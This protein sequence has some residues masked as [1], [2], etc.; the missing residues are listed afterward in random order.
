MSNYS[1]YSTF[2]DQDIVRGVCWSLAIISMPCNLIVI[3]RLLY[4]NYRYSKTT[5]KKSAFSL[6]HHR[7]AISR[8]PSIFLLFNLTLS[9]LVSSLYLLILAFSDV[10]YTDYY[11]NKYGLYPDYSNIT[12]DW[13][14]SST[15]TFERILSQIALLI[16][17]LMTFVVAVDRFILVVY[18]HSRRKI[19]V[20]GARIIS[21]V[22][23]LFALVIA[24]VAIAYS[25]ESVASRPRTRRDILAQLCLTDSSRSFVV[26][27]I[28]FFE[29]FLG[30]SMYVTAM[31]LYIII[32]VKLKQSKQF[33]SDSS[34]RIEKRISIILASVVFTNVFTYLPIT[35]IS[36]LGRYIPGFN[37]GQLF[38]TLVILLY[39]NAAVNPI[40]L[41][42]MSAGAV[43]N[44]NGNKII[45]SA[46]N[47]SGKINTT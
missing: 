36:I 3:I 21:L 19:T 28:T 43:S 47:T 29:L 45:H 26:F 40:L 30:C 22:C 17:I 24:I 25:L 44:G 37:S 13:V 46:T 2:L 14:L 39:L 8:N 10:Y 9:D 35:L 32:C 15:C 38:P 4:F 41:L 6:R 7:F 27:V 16:S 5:S 42:T 31:I 11:R 23:W 33:R 1:S 18:P 12:N 20:K 34:N